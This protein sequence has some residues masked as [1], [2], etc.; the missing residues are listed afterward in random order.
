MI[1]KHKYGFIVFTSL[2][3]WNKYKTGGR[4]GTNECPCKI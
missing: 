3:Y 2:S 4:E 1:Y